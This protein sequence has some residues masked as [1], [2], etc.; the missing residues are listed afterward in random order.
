MSL[1]RSVR[2]GSAALVSGALLAFTSGALAHADTVAFVLRDNR[3]SR[4]AGLAVNTDRGV[5]WAVQAGAG[6]G[7]VYAIKPDGS[8]EGRVL[9][10]AN[11]V[12]A[13]A[14]SLRGE[15][16]FVGDIGDA[17]AQRD[18]VSV[19]RLDDS[20]PRTRGANFTQW[21]FVYPNG[22]RDAAAMLVSP[23]GRI[24]IVTKESPQ[25][26]IYASPSPLGDGKNRLIEVGRAPAG[27][28]DAT[29]LI[30]GRMAL[31][32]SVS[33]EVLDPA[34]YVVTSQAALGGAMAGEALTTSLDRGGLLVG[35][36]GVDSKVYK[37]PLPSA[38]PP[39]ATTTAPSTP[40][41]GQPSASATPDPTQPTSTPANNGVV[42]ALL[43]AGA[44]ALA[45]GL[46]VYFR[47]S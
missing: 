23:T 36:L 42:W 25:G 13:Q 31:R 24:F 35:T 38:P 19:Y 1:R 33:V 17:K 41:S 45:A 11:L 12:D 16:V 28:T 27:V 47:R 44:L 21:D 10:D 6:D 2:R 43:G 32:T 46:V 39:S 15:K 5:Y 18:H 22:P 8:T 34:T 30:D 7:I 29:F 20:E 3:I 4:A 37:V 26:H 40:A 9:F 14:V